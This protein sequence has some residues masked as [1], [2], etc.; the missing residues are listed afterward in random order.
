MGAGSYLAGVGLAGQPPT[1]TASMQTG[2]TPIAGVPKF[3]PLTKTYPL[4]DGGGV[5]EVDAIWQ[6]VAHRLG[7]PLGSIPSAPTVGINVAR[8]RAATRANAQRTV[9]DVVSVALKPMIDRGDVAIDRV[10]LAQP[11]A[12]KWES[13]ITNLRENDPAARPFGSP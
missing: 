2:G 8:I 4:E 5:E 3:D 1:E 11:W 12:G 13:W 6:E 9:E 10:V 7:I